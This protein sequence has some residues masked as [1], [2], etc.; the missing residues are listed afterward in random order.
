MRTEPHPAARQKEDVKM[1]ILKIAL[2]AAFVS[3]PMFATVGASAGER[4]S[5]LSTDL[6]AQK[7]ANGARKQKPKLTRARWDGNC[8]ARYTG[9][10]LSYCL[11][12]SRRPKK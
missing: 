10:E 9:R 6:S 2:L 8:Y 11:G 4:P 1:K 5:I 7:K 12:H 3:A